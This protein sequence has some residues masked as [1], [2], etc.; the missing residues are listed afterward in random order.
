MRRKLTGIIVI[1]MAACV[2]ILSGCSGR[3][4]DGSMSHHQKPRPQADT[5]AHERVDAYAP[6]AMTADWGTPVRI[7]SPINT[8]DPED[9]I[10]I[11]PDGKYLYFMY[12]AGLL[13]N[14]PPEEILSFPNGTYRAKRIGGPGDFDYPV[15]YDLGEDIDFSLDGELSFSP[16]GTKVYFHSNRATNIGWQKEPPVEDYIDMYIA[17][18]EDGKPGQAINPGEPLNSPYPD[19]EHCMHP[20]GITLYFASHRP[21]GPGAVNIWKSVFDGSLWSMPEILPAPI[22]STGEDLQP[23]FTSDGKTMYFTSNRDNSIGSAIYRSKWDDVS[24]EW[25]PIE[26]IMQGIVGEPSI[27]ADG[28]L[29][30]FVHVLTDAEGVFDADVYYSKKKDN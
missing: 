8:Y 24:D 3:D 25:Q 20:D 18:I 12:T 17:E 7:G 2:F 29:L 16:D 30:Y 4:D 10:E 26:L 14:M 27:T 5:L 28:D 23:A 21:G 22:N 1:V 13:G 9:A 11:S 19:G 15:F 6:Q